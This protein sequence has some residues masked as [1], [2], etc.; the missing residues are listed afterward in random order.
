MKRIKS[1]ELYE[2]M[3]FSAPLFFDDGVNMF[4]AKRKPLK[5]H[6]MAALHRW[7][8]PFV[9]T[10]GT[11]YTD[12]SVELLDEEIADLEEFEEVLEEIDEVDG[13]QIPSHNTLLQIAQNFH[14][15]M[16][17]FPKI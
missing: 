12:P 1:E 3:I 11:L 15:Q 2:G 17:L 10:Y 7:N 8:I 5:K 13:V 16:N 6:H 4:L 9:L 14:L